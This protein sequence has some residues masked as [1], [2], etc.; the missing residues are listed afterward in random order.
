MSAPPV[1]DIAAG[2]EAFSTA[3]RAFHEWEA[4]ELSDNLNAYEATRLLSTTTSSTS[5]VLIGTGD[6]TF[7]VASGL[8]FV[9]GQS[10]N[11]ISTANPAN[12]MSGF[13]KS[14]SSTTLLITVLS[15]TGSGTLAS[16][17]IALGLSGGG[18]GL[19][20]NNFTG[21]QNFAQGTD[22]ASA[23][24]INLT[25]ATG[26]IVNVTGT[27]GT[28]A[29]TLGAGM[30]RL[31][32]AVGAWPLTYNATTNNITGGAN[33]TLA[34]GDMVLYQNL[35][36]VVY[37]LIIKQSGRALIETNKIEPITAS[38]SANALTITINP[39]AL[40]FRSS[41]LS[42]GAVNT[43]IIGAA[44]SMGVSSGSTLGTIS[45]LQSRIAVLAIDN[46]G[47]VEV[48]CVNMAGGV[49]L[50]E[51]GLISTT[52][53]GGAGA[54]D[55]DNVVYSTTAR[56]N[57]PYRVLGYI[58]STQATAGTWAAAPSLIQGNGGQVAGLFKGARPN[59]TS[60]DQT[61][62]FNSLLN[63]AHGL[64]AKPSFYTVQLKCVTAEGNFSVGNEVFFMQAD[65]AGVNATNICVDAT[66]VSITNATSIRLQNKTAFTVFT[67]T[68]AN[69]RWVV[70]A[71]L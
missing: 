67:I 48:A 59:F 52:A 6:K 68:P 28:S 17:A 71:W 41:T 47:T 54:A 32:R 10:V 61:V 56:T 18:A 24:T 9:P 26:N 60:T 43:R 23:A 33:T 40:D 64:G 29:V 4:T 2:N 50:S 45:A 53:E 8:G 62:T 13:V 49:D 12:S 14:Y 69:W 66:N 65:V 39:T 55:S 70:R 21:V 44:I 63:V 42:S 25:T 7:T 3:M 20:T 16:W 38:V 58:Q 30:T 36:G 37:G 19:G 34:P 31:V 57:V 22:I 27:V 1:P 46:A 15:I 51:T 11:V 5:S 35:S